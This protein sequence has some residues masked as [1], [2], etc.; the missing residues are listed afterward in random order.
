MPANHHSKLFAVLLMAGAL[1]AFGACKDQGAADSPAAKG[2]FAY[3][4]KDSN[5]V[6][7]IYPQQ[8]ASSNLFK[9][10]VEPELAKN[11]DYQKVKEKCGFDPLKE[12]A[13]IV[14]GGK[15]EDSDNMVIA[16]NGITKEQFT[17]CV[18]AMSPE[19]EEPAKVT[20]EGDF[21]K[22]ESQGETTWFGWVDAKTMVMAPEAKEK[23]RIEAIVK[24]TDGLDKN[25]NMMKLVEKVDKKAAI[26]FAVHNDKPDQPLEGVP[27]PAKAVFG[28]LNF[29]QGMA[30]QFTLQQGTPEEAQKTVA[31]LTGQLGMVKQ[32]MPALSKLELK[33]EGSDVH[34]TLNMN[35]AEVK[36]VAPMVQQQINGMMG[37]MMG[38]GQPP[39]PEEPAADPGATAPAAGDPGAAGAEGAAQPATGEPAAGEGAKPEGQ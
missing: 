16:V 36:E 31:D 5:L 22:V 23:A 8:V 15:T 38:G 28:W 12:I 39:M 11:A 35:D 6:V 20:E 17:K 21:V 37:G 34:V 2:Q 18:P 1:F 10:F 3:L 14:I 7:G 24:T 26:W 33:A 25:E 9:E 32:M 19:G 4:P 13:G 30:F 29:S 27:V